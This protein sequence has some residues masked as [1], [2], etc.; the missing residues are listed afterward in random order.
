MR[1]YI[2]YR[3]M[4]DS[5]GQPNVYACKAGGKTVQLAGKPETG[6][7]VYPRTVQIAGQFIA[8]AAGH[9]TQGDDDVAVLHRVNMRSGK[10]R[11][12][13]GSA[14]D[15]VFAAVE[16]KAT[17]S[18]AWTVE[19]ENAN[20]ETVWFVR[21]LERGKTTT[22]DSGKDVDPD[23]LAA[24]RSILYWTKAGTAYSAAFS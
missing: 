21:K 22:L 20:R 23:S 3:D 17:G 7:G 5:G 13:D 19:A 18:V 16:L 9:A 6:F 4:P 10:K 11:I 2:P 8:Y 24:A 12:V 1:V 15:A 14:P